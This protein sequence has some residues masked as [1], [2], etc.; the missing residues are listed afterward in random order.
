MSKTEVQVHAEEHGA[1]VSMPETIGESFDG[2]SLADSLKGVKAI[3]FDFDRVSLVTSFGIREWVRFLKLLPDEAYYC[4]ARCPAMVVA[5]L[6][7]IAGFAG[8]GEVVSIYLPYVCPRCGDR[9]ELLLD[10][11]REKQGPLRYPR[12][13]CA[14]CE[15]ESELDD[16]PDVYL[17]YVSKRPR[18]SPKSGAVPLLATLRARRGKS[19]V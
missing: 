10:L 2:P 18:P 19:S 3:V 9:S 17:S 4:F 5:Q 7:T 8:R 6:N 1:R 15:V 13:T 16:S 12:V 14:R 11:S